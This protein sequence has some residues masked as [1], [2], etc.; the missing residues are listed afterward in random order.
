M[1]SDFTWDIDIVRDGV[2]PTLSQQIDLSG[3]IEDMPF[4]PLVDVDM[5]TDC[6]CEKFPNTGLIL[7]NND[8]FD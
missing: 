3:S 8:I 6:N 7:K 4:A 5:G 2:I 1:I